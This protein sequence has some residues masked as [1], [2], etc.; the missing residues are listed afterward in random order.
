L[1]CYG[2]KQD[3]LGVGGWVVRRYRGVYFLVV[4]VVVSRSSEK[5]AAL[6]GGGGWVFGEQRANVGAGRPR[7]FVVSE[8]LVAGEGGEEGGRGKGR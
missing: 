7:V 8:N 5:G 2:L 4:G 3:G 1:V 6:V